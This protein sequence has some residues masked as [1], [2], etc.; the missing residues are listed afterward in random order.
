MTYVPHV[1]AAWSSSNQKLSVGII[2]PYT[3]Q[4]VAIQ[5]RLGHKYEKI[6][7]FEVKVKSVDGFQG[8]EEDI[9]IISTVR[10]NWSGAI[11]F[12]N[13]LQRTNVALTR[14]RYAIFFFA[15]IFR[16][17]MVCYYLFRPNS[18][19]ACILDTVCGY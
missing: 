19:I 6:E 2:S 8:G 13:S 4:V 16:A 15:I 14:A 11:G 1:C 10:S 5:Q 17:S 18:F 12:M 3:A 9:V 7:G